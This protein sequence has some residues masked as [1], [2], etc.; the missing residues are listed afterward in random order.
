MG[1]LVY[2][3]SASLDGYIE[4]ENGAFDW[5][6]PEGVHEFI[7][8]LV[9]PIGTVLLGRRL[10]ETMAYWD[11]PVQTYPP[12]GREFARVWH[13][14][15]KIVFSRTLTAAASPNTHI[16]RDFDVEAI[17]KLKHESQNDAM[18]GGAE[19]AGLAI[20][21]DLV[22]ECHVFLD[23]VVVGGG[24]PA[25][26]AGLRANLDLLETRRFDSGV[27]HVRY[28]I[29]R[30]PARSQNEITRIATSS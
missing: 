1:K 28:R 14:R 5:V 29:R 18:I 25:F 2:I 21:A 30:D 24:K 8:D 13:D 9:R 17:R 27:V 6:T 23:P 3:T 16:E 20:E 22:D 10:Y 7:T 19:I 15:R 11:A 12:E 26:R 4:D